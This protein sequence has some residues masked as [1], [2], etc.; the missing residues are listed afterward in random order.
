MHPTDKDLT[1]V[2]HNLGNSLLKEQKLDKAI[3]AYKSA[4]RIN[5]NDE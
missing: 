1:K 2:Y 5:P 4:L 3:E